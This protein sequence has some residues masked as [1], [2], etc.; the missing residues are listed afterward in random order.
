MASRHRR[1]SPSP[2]PVQLPPQHP[3]SAQPAPL[4]HSHIHPPEP[5]LPPLPPSPTHMPLVSPAFPLST[6]P[7]HPLRLCPP[8]IGRLTTATPGPHMRPPH[9]PESLIRLSK[10]N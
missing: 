5:L 8:L 7:S 3:P 4:H 9:V 6:S 1:H 2:P 10:A